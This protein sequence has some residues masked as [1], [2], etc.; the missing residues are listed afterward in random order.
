M[1]GNFQA[2]KPKL[3]GLDQV[4][5]EVKNISNSD[6]NQNDNFHLKKNRSTSKN[7]NQIINLNLM[8]NKN[9]L[10]NPQNRN[11]NNKNNFKENVNENTINEA[12]NSPNEI[13]IGNKLAL[14]PNNNP[15][16]IRTRS[17]GIMSFGEKEKSSNEELKASDGFNLNSVSESKQKLYEGDVNNTNNL[18][19]N[20]FIMDINKNNKNSKNTQNINFP[21]NYEKEFIDNNNNENTQPKNNLNDNIKRKNSNIR[22]SRTLVAQNK[23]GGVENKAEAIRNTDNASFVSK[24][25][26]LKKTISDL[27]DKNI[28]A[29]IMT[30]A[31][32]YALILSDLNIIFF[33]QD[34]DIIFNIL[35]GVVFILF[36]AEFIL[37][38]TTKEDYNGTFFFWL[39]L[40]SILSMILNID[41]IIYP[42]LELIS[43]STNSDTSVSNIGLQKVVRNLGGVVK[44]TRYFNLFQSY[45]SKFFKLNFTYL[46][47]T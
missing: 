44:L 13:I 30:I 31:T 9:D 45:L 40:F 22:N 32:I 39:D 15:K 3:K 42:F 47:K 26:S 34:V 29:L 35:S 17:R 24:N 7:E 20:D 6:N 8:E 4:E 11:A 14:K 2:E 21:P 12:S 46:I 28:T 1:N 43:Q 25:V 10:S 16:I 38:T 27:L 37:S 5:T 18:N 36:L 19:L 41:W 23:N 33:S